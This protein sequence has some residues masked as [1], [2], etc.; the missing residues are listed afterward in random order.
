[1]AHH[2]SDS[3]RDYSSGVDESRI[4]SSLRCH[5][6]VRVSIGDLW[7]TNLSSRILLSRYTA[8]CKQSGLISSLLCDRSD[9]DGWRSRRVWQAG[10]ASDLCRP[11]LGSA[12]DDRRHNFSLSFSFSIAI[13]KHPHWSPA[14]KRVFSTHVNTSVLT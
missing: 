5:L 4:S 1:M 10:V 13:Y 7:G 12:I 9:T 14:H 11:S 2:R 8:V 6:F 3:R